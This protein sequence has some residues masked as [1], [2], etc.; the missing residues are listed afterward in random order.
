MLL[1]VSQEMGQ[2]E[3]VLMQTLHTA[4]IHCENGQPASQHLHHNM[5]FLVWVQ[6]MG[7][8]HRARPP[9]VQTS[10]LLKQQELHFH[11][12]ANIAC[13]MAGDGVTA[14]GEAA[15]GADHQDSHRAPRTVQAR[16]R[17]AVP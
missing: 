11:L 4:C 2:G 13:A 9:V 6:E 16:Q 5:N 3:L 17:Q 10:S 12:I 7:F 8:R 15:G 1:V 14:Q